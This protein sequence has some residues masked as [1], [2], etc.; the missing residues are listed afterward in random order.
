MALG[1]T[2]PRKVDVR[3]P[4]KGNSNFHGARPVHQIISMI[5]CSRTSRLSTKNSRF[6][7]RRGGAAGGVRTPHTLHPAPY[8]LH[9]TPYTLNPVPLP[10]TLHP[11]PSHPASISPRSCCKCS[12]TLP[13]SPLRSRVYGLERKRERGSERGSERERERERRYRERVNRL[14][15]LAPRPSP[16]LGLRV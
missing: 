10:F 1:F 16:P 2:L 11:T 3:V 15:P 8:T 5:K 7:L 4:E 14:S 13:H 9:P 12:R 6:S